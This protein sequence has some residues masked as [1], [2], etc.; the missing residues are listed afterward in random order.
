M[1]A[2]DLCKCFKNTMPIVDW[3]A[4]RDSDNPTILIRVMPYFLIR[5]EKQRINNCPQCGLRVRDLI[6]NEAELEQLKH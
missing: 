4:Y 1:K 3:M 5:G 2:S 6:L